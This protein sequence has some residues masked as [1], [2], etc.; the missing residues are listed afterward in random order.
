MKLLI[1]ADINKHKKKWE[2]VQYSF[3]VSIADTENRGC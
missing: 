3:I 2:T 1:K